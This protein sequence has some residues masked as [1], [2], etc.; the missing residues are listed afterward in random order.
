MQ[1]ILHFVIFYWGKPKYLEKK[2]SK[3]GC[4]GIKPNWNSQILKSNYT[5]QWLHDRIM[6][7][8]D[9]RTFLSVCVPQ[10]KFPYI[11]HNEKSYNT[12]ENC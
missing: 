4:M 5:T 11:V 2:E 3:L 6:L 8:H 10:A 1:T 12:H 7:M 9:R